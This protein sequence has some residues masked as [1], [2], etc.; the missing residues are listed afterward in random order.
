MESSTFEE[1]KTFIAEIV[2]QLDVGVDKYRIGFAQYSRDG[3]VEFLLKTYENKG[4]VLNHI[5]SSV[6]FL[7]GPLQTGSALRFLRNTYFTEEAGSRLNQGTPQYTV[8]VTSA[9]SEDDVTEAAQELKETG[10]NVVTVGVLNSDSEE[11]HTVATSPWV[12][13]VNDEQSASQFH[14]DV[15]D[16]LEG[17]ALQEFEDARVA[18]VP[19]GTVVS[20]DERTT[21]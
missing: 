15:V 19:G 2:E 16:I 1:I 5:Q 21:C 14:K 17:P 6:P 11:L 9:E 18:E 10:V 4:D 13:Q 12:F 3:Q 20:I 8:V 7:E